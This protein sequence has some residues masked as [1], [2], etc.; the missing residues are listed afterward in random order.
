MK[1]AT[2]AVAILLGFVSGMLFSWCHVAPNAVH[3]ERLKA[4]DLS[5][6][7]YQLDPRTGQVVFKYL[8]LKEYTD[9]VIRLVTPTKVPPNGF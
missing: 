9:H 2:I 6:G 8:D 5:L 3:H 1:Y 7:Q 4:F